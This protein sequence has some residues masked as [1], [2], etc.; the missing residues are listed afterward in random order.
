MIWGF[1]AAVAIIA[2]LLGSISSSII[3]SK[4]ISGKD[5]RE[6]GSGNAGAT[7]MLRT[8]GKK[9]GVLTLICDMLKGVVAISL[10]MLISFIL[11]KLVRPSD[12]LA[13]G[14]AIVNPTVLGK[15]VSDFE[16]FHVIPN[17]KYIAALFVVLGHIFP[18]FFGFK[19]GKGIATSGA[20]VLMLNWKIGLVI[21]AVALITMIIT[22]YV[23]LGSVVSSIAY[24]I[25]LAGYL[26][27]QGTFSNE[28][29]PI[30]QIGFAIILAFI[31]TYKHKENIKRL[32]AGTESK[33]G[34]KKKEIKE[35]NSSE[36]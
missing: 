17:L 10:A 9:A 28:N 24:P 5:I 22:R 25:V 6:S 34:Q 36:S 15:A 20:V 11:T 4:I 8:H 13:L 21:T 26:I 35:D 19:G 2:Y 29:N 16:I 23:S 33:L 1:A 3:I 7:N 27:G 32:L 14:E 12:Y 31:C 18:V 30:V